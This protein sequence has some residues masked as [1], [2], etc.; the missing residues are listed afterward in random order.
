M[1]PQVSGLRGREGRS[2]RGHEVTR[3]GQLL[4]SYDSVWVVRERVSMVKERVSVLTALIRDSMSEGY[5]GQ[6]SR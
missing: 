6:S 2:V 1:T 4:V 5:K 3:G